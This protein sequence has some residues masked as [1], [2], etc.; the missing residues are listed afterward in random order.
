ME[1]GR[2][3]YRSKITRWIWKYVRLQNQ[4][5]LIANFYENHI[6]VIGDTYI[7]ANCGKIFY[8]DEN[9][10]ADSLAFYHIEE[11]HMNLLDKEEED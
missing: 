7:C 4:L 6:L 1:F 9:I 10:T 5:N 11:E 2:R 8:D 3:V